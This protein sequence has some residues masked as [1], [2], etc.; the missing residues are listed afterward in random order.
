MVKRSFVRNKKC[1]KEI[2]AGLREREWLQGLDWQGLG[3]LY[4]L[5]S[6]RGYTFLG[7]GSFD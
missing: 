3:S 7:M 5:F 6:Y 1:S 4:P 2:G